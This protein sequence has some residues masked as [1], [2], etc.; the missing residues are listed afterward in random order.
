[1]RAPARQPAVV[2]ELGRPETPEETAARKADDSRKHRSRQTV[3]NLVLSLLAILGV[4]LIIV[5]VVP[6][7]D[8]PVAPKVDYAQLAAAG[9]GSEPDPL[10][11]PVLPNSWHANAAELRTGAA[12]RIDSWY[13]GLITPKQ[14]YIGISQGF[15]ANAT[16]LADQ[17]R[18]SEPDGSITID[19]VV[20]TR[21]DN[22][23]S[24]GDFG[25][26]QYALTTASGAS[27]YVIFGTA[28]D[29]E[30]RTVAQAMAGAI[31][32]Q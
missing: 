6:R 9:Q 14:Q 10:V 28:G 21:Y 7:A 11:S 12:D 13:I 31:R 25:N 30:F 2:A 5:M 8:A 26:V 15:H 29:Q 24:G 32:A 22:R 27:T 17:L 4:V 16:W 20:W 3:N 23:A 19:S 1:M 18:S